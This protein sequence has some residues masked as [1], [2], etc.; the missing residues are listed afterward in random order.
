[1]PTMGFQEHAPVHGIYAIVVPPLLEP[2][3]E[4]RVRHLQRLNMT[5]SPVTRLTAEL[6]GVA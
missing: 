1:M 2:H 4:S 3:P 5:P 6:R